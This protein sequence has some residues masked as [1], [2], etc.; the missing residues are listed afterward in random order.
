LEKIWA[1]AEEIMRHR[2][3][4]DLV[5]VI[6]WLEKLGFTHGD[7]A[8]RN[9]AV[10]SSNRLK[11]FDFGSAT[12]NDHYDYT[13]DVKRDHSGLATYLHYILTGVDPFANASSAQ[14]VRQI[15]NQ[16]RY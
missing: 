2:W 9:L 11:L 14:E 8:V 15:E 13:A 4:R 12:T 7:L 1:D 5:D 3:I 6:S 10:D 16:R